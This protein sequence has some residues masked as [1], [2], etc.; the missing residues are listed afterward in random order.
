VIFEYR[1]SGFYT[2]TISTHEKDMIQNL[3]KSQQQNAWSLSKLFSFQKESNESVGRSFLP[4]HVSLES[5]AGNLVAF[6]QVRSLFPF[7]I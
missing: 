5:N 7:R 6:L 1:V 4:W 3:A 2:D